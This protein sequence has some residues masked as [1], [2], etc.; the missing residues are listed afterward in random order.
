METDAGLV[1]ALGLLRD[2]ADN[3]A[4]I[5]ATE[6][7]VASGYLRL[8]TATIIDEATLAER[9]REPPT[10]ALVALHRPTPSLLRALRECPPA[11]LVI[12]GEADG[13]MAASLTRLSDSA[14]LGPAATLEVGDGNL[15]LC[16]AEREGLKELHRELSPE[17]LGIH[18]APTPPWLVTWL[19]STKTLRAIGF[20]HSTALDTRWSQWIRNL[21]ITEAARHLLVPLGI[22][23]PRT[24]LP[25]HPSLGAAVA[26]H[27]L[28]RTSGPVYPSARVVAA[29]L[30]DPKPDSAP[31]RPTEALRGRW[32]QARRA[33]PLTGATPGMEEPLPSLCSSDPSAA[34]L[35][36]RTL[37]RQRRSL[38]LTQEHRDQDFVDADPAGH[39]RSLEVLRGAGE[40]LSEHE[41][42]VVLHGFGIEVTRQAVASSASGAASF[43]EKIGFPVVLKAVS[44]DLRRKRELGAVV[45]DL[46]TAASVRRAYASIIA[47][48]QH[49][50]P[51]AHIDG[52]LV[53]EQIEEGLELQ[54]GAVRLD[55]GEIALY[56]RP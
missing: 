46:K 26:A 17:L 7:S 44:P 15:L 16:A 25:R 51:A 29:I 45:L 22:E 23:A 5:V 3:K 54:C 56:G 48:V 40:V 39:D 10:P 31:H 13:E 47:N 30:R 18:L 1:R 42:K 4:E 24:D 37:L 32:I 52:V 50:A 36:Q 20:V 43:A 38:S 19:Q 55:S 12:T 2:A 8:K 14:L 34:Y 41:S 9:L 27:A 11:L 33:L 6:T 49:K 53:A 21:E 28:E 35:A